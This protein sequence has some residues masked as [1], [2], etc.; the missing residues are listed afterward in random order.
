[1]QVLI[2]GVEFSDCVAAGGLKWSR[3]DID[4]PNAGRNKAGTMIRDRITTKMRCDW[5]ARP[6]P[7][8]RHRSLMRAI[9]PEYISITYND[10]VYGRG[11][12]V[13]YVSNATA[14]HLMTRGGED[15]WHN[16]QFASIER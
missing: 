1:M 13:M 6:L 11:S 8:A 2:D 3:N 7:D 14:E 10:P 15:W 4:G 12:R 9:L 5:K 16:T